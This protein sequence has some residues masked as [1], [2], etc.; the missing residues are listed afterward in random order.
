MSQGKILVV[1][2]EPSIGRLLS[3]QLHGF[4][5]DVCYVQD[6]LQALE[7]V[8]LEQPDLIL[9]DVMMPLVSGWD[10]CREIRSCSSVPIIMLTG[11]NADADVVE[12]LQAGADDYVTKP[13]S[14]PQLHARIEAVMRRVGQKAEDRRRRT[15]ERPSINER[16]T[17]DD[18]RPTTDDRRLAPAD[19]RQLAT[20]DRQPATGDQRPATSDRRLA[21]ADDRRPATGDRRL[22]TSDRPLAPAD[23]RWLAPADDRRPAT[24]DRPLAPAGKSPAASLPAPEPV[25]RITKPIGV[26]MREV[27]LERGITLYQAERFCRIRWEFLQALEQENWSYLPPKQLRPALL[28]YSGFLGLDSNEVAGR[29]PPTSG[30]PHLPAVALTLVL[31]LLIAV[32][33]TLL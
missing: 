25:T 31:V 16:P 18:R 28:A 27:R 4:G 12:G 33:L 9:L 17:T 23:D 32:G 5:Y 3:Y 8:L 11:K 1:D 7:R 21:P 26:R 29:L 14:L 30:A 13:F 24:S 19:D 10:V 2:D 20:G 15:A 22:A 6:G